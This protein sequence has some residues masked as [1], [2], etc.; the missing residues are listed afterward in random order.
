VAVLRVS[1]VIVAALAVAGCAD[2]RRGTPTEATIASAPTTGGPCA[3][4]KSAT[5]PPGDVGDLASLTEAGRLGATVLIARIADAPTVAEDSLRSPV[6]YESQP[7]VTD[8]GPFLV[9][10]YDLT[11]QQLVVWPDSAPVP[12]IGDHL[13]LDIG[14][15]TSGCLTLISPNAATLEPGTSYLVTAGVRQPTQLIL[16]DDRYAMRLSSDGIIEQEP[17]GSSLPA[18]L[19]ELIGKPTSSLPPAAVVHSQLI[20]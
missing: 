7:G 11:V 3:T 12:A 20:S 8:A 13:Q 9:T 19:T 18:A 5:L 1:C 14:G 6:I 16:W 10:R 15:G 4:P 17:A 2:T